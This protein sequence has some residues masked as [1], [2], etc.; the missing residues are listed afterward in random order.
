MKMKRLFLAMLSA[1]LLLAGCTSEKI[2]DEPGLS[3]KGSLTLQ[4]TPSSVITK[5]PATDKGYEY[6]TEEEL[7]VAN[8]RVFVFD[9]NGKC[10]KN[11]LYDNVTEATNPSYPDNINGFDVTYTKGY[12]VVIPDLDYGTYDF[13][14][15]AN[16]ANT[17]DYDNCTTI[18]GLKA[19]VEG[20]DTYD[21]AFTGRSDKLVKFGNKTAEFSPTSGSIQIPL[22]QLAARVEL[23]VKVTLPK[24]FVSGEYD[25]GNVGE[26]G[27]LTLDDVEKLI[28]YKP[29]DQTLTND[30]LLP[31]VD[32]TYNYT[33]FEHPLTIPEEVN[34]RVAKYV[35]I[36]E[37]S[38]DKYTTNRG[39]FMENIQLKVV[40]I[41]V[42]S[43]LDPNNDS[44]IE[45]V[46]EVL[47][48]A[49]KSDLYST[50]E[51][52]EIH[53]IYQFYTYPT[54][55]LSVS[56]SGDL[57]PSTFTLKQT[58]VLKNSIFVNDK[59]DGGIPKLIT[60]IRDNQEGIPAD[61]VLKLEG[62]NGW[63]NKKIG[64]LLTN[65]NSWTSVG[66]SIEGEPI[67]GEK[68]DF[69][70]LQAELAPTNGFKMGNLYIGNATL[71]KPDEPE[72][73]VLNI[74]NLQDGGSINIGFE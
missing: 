20:G 59:V 38:V 18:E 17:T 36:P 35:E 15:V 33:Y 53:N 37:I 30:M 32:G 46:G 43:P 66:G 71:T 63:S 55:Q 39:H 67:I 25:Y 73:F 6:A 23:T 57:Y 11:I 52:I 41:R 12:E 69:T 2:I 4:L 27:I 29:K 26:N 70:S 56:L 8:C 44:D 51:S 28:G 50:L 22:T 61:E 16:P 68:I 1:G 58:G 60:Y 24:S 10:I 13:Y 21:E 42:K 48:S 74:A 65:E 3:G 40:G 62:G 72:G 34:P 64:L 49:E 45:N 9:T 54:D 31:N 19:I 7:N 14:V 47:F 5:A